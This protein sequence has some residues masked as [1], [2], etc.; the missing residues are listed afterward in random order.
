MS[1]L[2]STFLVYV[3][4]RTRFLLD[5]LAATC[6][7]SR[8]HFVLIPIAILIHSRLKST[9][10]VSLS[11]SR[12]LLLF[13][14]SCS[15]FAS[16][17]TMCVCVLLIWR[18]GKSPD[19][20]TFELVLDCGQI[21]CD[22]FAVVS[23]YLF[24]FVALLVRHQSGKR[25]ELCW[26]DFAA[27]LC[28]FRDSL[29]RTRLITNDELRFLFHLLGLSFVSDRLTLFIL[30]RSSFF[31]V[32]LAQSRRTFCHLRNWIYR[33]ELAQ[34]GIPCS[35]HLWRAKDRIAPSTIT[36]SSSHAFT[37]FFTFSSP[38]T[39]VER[40]FRFRSS[41]FIFRHSLLIRDTS[42]TYVTWPSSLV[43]AIFVSFFGIFSRT[44]FVLS[45]QAQIFEYFIVAW[46]TN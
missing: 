11:L 31:F 21:S 20:H 6:S 28:H 29:S 12:F 39:C 3:E 37:F 32:L 41:S 8:I 30:L 18:N 45:H 7:T 46:L 17:W 35:W 9:L 13:F 44:A 27:L 42:V 25:A 19:V 36:F 10:A 4:C 1:T 24:L 26:F 23:N 15:S 22:I 33:K 34:V 40:I 5:Q 16:W 14:S 38:G 43:L 2:K